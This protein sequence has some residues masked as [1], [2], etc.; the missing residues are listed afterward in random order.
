MRIVP[1]ERAQLADLFERT[2]PD[3]PTVLPGWRAK[4]LLAH[5]LVRERN[6]AAAPGILV[7]PLARFTESAMRSYERKPWSRRVQLLRS[8]PPPW[9][10]YYLPPVDE[11]VNL[12]EFFVHHE[13]LSRA[14][15]GWEPRPA[16]DDRDEA[17]WSV[18]RLLGRVLY[19][20]SPVGVLLRHP[21]RPRNAEINA[22]PGDRRV[23]VVGPPGE[24]LLH[25][26]GRDLGQVELQGAPA[27]VAALNGAPRG[28]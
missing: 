20:H 19:R 28:I 25:G 1:G 17:L 14:R 2:G 11:R 15:P 24:L 8:G 10:P 16:D 26:F 23:T 3:A 13:D 22:R 9:S 27:D 18:L 21:T 5:L 4:E 12:A 7:S 6:P